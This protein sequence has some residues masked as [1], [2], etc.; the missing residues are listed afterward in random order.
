MINKKNIVFIGFLSAYGGAEKS[1]VMIA[2]ELA[3]LGN[4][5]TIISLKD[6]N[7]VYEIGDNIK[8]LYIQ[9]K[10][11]NRIKNL[12]SRFLDLKKTLVEIKPDLVI[13]FWLQPAI[14]STI[15]SK[16]IGFK[17]IYSERGDPT[18]KEYNGLLGI[19]R[20]ICFKFV[21]GFV[22]QTE[23]AKNCFQ[24]S[25]QKKGTIINNPVYIKYNDFEIP[26]LRRNVIVNV[27]RF[28]EQKNQKLLI[29]AF[30][31]VSDIF[32]EYKLEI[33][34]D[35]DLKG[36]LNDQIK[37][38]NLNNKVVLKGTTDNLFEE[39]VDANLFVLSSD[40]EGMPNALME[41]MALGIPCIST[42]CKPG[43]ARELIEHS[44]NGLISKRLSEKDLFESIKYM[45]ENP[46]EA[47][48][49]GIKAKDICNTHSVK[50]IIK[51]WEEYIKRVIER[52]IV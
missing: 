32:P 46:T 12:F 26:Q 1:M 50:S 43:G 6:N 51:M 8:Y 4:E 9:D 35:G 16:F 25:V 36:N 42:D 52:D 41:A 48:I 29:N 2:N 45:L 24:K 34:G 11:A 17:T 47:E 49:M 14:L 38:L 27:G 13:S 37:K 31:K 20:S 18:D 30:A 28:H 3:N 23:G 22:F 7:V 15:L 19:V 40:Y 44:V 33:Y 39:I 21:D 10:K 5:V